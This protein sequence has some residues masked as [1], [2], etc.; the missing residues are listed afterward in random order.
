MMEGSNV[1]IQAKGGN[2]PG[3]GSD[4]MPTVTGLSPHKR[5]ESRATSEEQSFLTSFTFALKGN[6][7]SY[8][9]DTTN[10]LF[11]FSGAFVG[12]EDIVKR[13]T[14][15][16]ERVSDLLRLFVSLQSVKL[17]C[18]AIGFGSI[19]FAQDQSARSSGSKDALPWEEVVRPEGESKD[20]SLI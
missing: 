15:D 16:A 18:K 19:S 1:T 3:S 11:I 5:G 14:R 17:A 12:L 2:N 8:T 4:A 20:I 6:Q 13:R 7:E 9:V 10:I